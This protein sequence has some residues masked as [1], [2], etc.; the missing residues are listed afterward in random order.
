MIRD[1]RALMVNDS[2]GQFDEDM[3]SSEML[4]TGHSKFSLKGAD[5]ALFKAVSICS[6][7]KQRIP[8]YMH[9]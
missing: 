8:S 5:L 3:V 4:S 2:M 9:S 1:S 7:V 6:G